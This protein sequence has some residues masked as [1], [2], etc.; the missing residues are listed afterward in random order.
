MGPSGDAG[1]LRDA[2][3]LAVWWDEAYVGAAHVFDTTRK[4]ARVVERLEVGAVAGVVLH[5]PDATALATARVGIERVHE[6][7]YLEALTTGEPR[8]LAESQG[9][10]WDPGIWTMAL[11][12]TAGVVAAATRALAVGRAGSLSS[13][14]HHARPGG[15][16]G[17]CT[18]NG[19][20]VAAAHALDL[21]DADGRRD[22]EVVVLDVDAHCGGGTHAILERDPGLAARVRQLDLSVDAFDAY[23]A[24]PA[25][26][27]LVLDEDLD[28]DGYLEALDG[29]LDRI[30]PV[31]TALV[32][33]N[34]GM[35]PFPVVSRAALVE[36]E[37]RIVARLRRLGIPVAFVLAGGY[38][39]HQT[40]DEL[41]DLH[42]GTIAAHAA[43]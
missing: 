9:F 28:D 36:R 23:D 40:L 12:S 16:S 26:S 43:P 29:L 25:H 24:D 41:V 6:P 10:T 18:V 34:A 22:A 4:S 39:V 1:E 7:A 42:L 30:D 33:H 19:L 38:T 32:L 20:A 15:G 14:L 35:D 11:H 8:W 17:F 5:A 31:R 13:G 3:P 27:V 21:L 37:R 2:P